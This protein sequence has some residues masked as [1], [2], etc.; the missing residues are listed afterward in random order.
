MNL[1]FWAKLERPIMIPAPMSGVTDTVFRRIMLRHGRPDVFF[2]WFVSCDGLCSPGRDRLL[3]DLEFDQTE[4]PIV[5]QVFG[6][7]PET[8]KRTAELLAERGFDGID[9]NAGC[10][11]RNVEKQGAGAVLMRQPELLAEIVAA[12]KEGAGELPVSIKTRLGY[13]AIII[14]ELMAQLLAM[15]PAAITIHART[16]NERYRPPAHWD[17]IARAVRLAR[18]AGSESLIIGNGDVKT[19]AQAEARVAETGVD[20]VMIG[21]ALIGN[22]WFFDRTRAGETP[23]RDERIAALLEHTRLFH[24]VYGANRHFDVLKKH[25]KAYC[26][27]FR[28]AK[29]LRVKLMAASSAADVEEI[30]ANHP[31]ERAQP[32]CH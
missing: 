4:R 31:R 26:G 6:S 10:P 14:D 24:D 1:G 2:T 18:E 16:R 28:G 25:F 11:D 27:G 7:R 20:G 9:V 3:P 23:G 21:R 17:Q 32:T 13:D 12:A 8:C 5:A 22:P 29:E 15:T 30:V 19:M